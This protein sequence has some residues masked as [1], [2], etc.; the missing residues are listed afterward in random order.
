MRHWNGIIADF[1]EE[2]AH[3]P[4]IEE[5]GTDHI[6]GREWA[7]GFMRG[8]LDAQMDGARESQ[9]LLQALFAR[10]PTPYFP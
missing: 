9:R 7:R 3:L 2:T 4:Y 10:Q 1:S 6:P 5:P 8:T